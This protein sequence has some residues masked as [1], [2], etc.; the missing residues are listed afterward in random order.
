MDLRWNIAML[1]IRARRFLKNTG[2]KLDMDN[3]ERIGFEKIKVECFNCHKRGHFA[4]ECKAPRNQDSRKSEPIR[5]TVPIMNK[6]KTGFGYNVVPPPYT[7]NF[8][9]PKPDLVYPSLDDFVDKFVS[10]SEVEKPTAESNEP[11]TARKENRAPII[12]DWV[13]KSEE[14][15]EPKDKGVID[16][17]CSRHMTGNKSYLTYYK[18]IDGGFVSFGVPRKDNMYSI[19]LRNVILQGGLTCL[20]AKA[21]S[22]ESNLWHMRLGHV[23]FKTI[24]KLVNRNLVRGRKPALSFMRP[25]GCPV[26]ILNT[27]DHLG[28]FDGKADEGFFVGYS[29]NSKAFRVFNSR[30]RILEKNLHVK[31]SESTTN[32]AGSRPNWLFDI[33]ALTKS[34]N[35]KPV[36]EENQSNGSAGTKACNNVGKTSV[37]T[38]P[39]KDY[40]LLP[41]WTQEPL[42]SFSSKDSPGAGY[43]QSGEEEKC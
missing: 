35:Y 23:N 36:V 40:I 28:K 1:T 15:Y 24:N 27:I 22:E 17:G 29:T 8:M 12:E 37:E 31:F 39:D 34:M 43:K 32:I 10:E 7:R 3:K 13:S 30:T 25:F 14:E 2:R 5:R 20:F 18:E 26:T 33:D 16:N 11:K 4:R 9:P 38:V 21:T 42:F 6:C 41:L 19:D